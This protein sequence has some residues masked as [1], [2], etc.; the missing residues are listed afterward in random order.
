MLRYQQQF[1]FFDQANVGGALRFINLSE[2]VMNKD[3]GAILD[4]IVKEVEFSQAHMVNGGLVPRCGAQ[5]TKR[6]VRIGS[7]ILRPAIGI[8]LI[9]IKATNPILWFKQSAEWR[10]AKRQKTA[11]RF[12]GRHCAD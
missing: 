1:T 7:S 5:S 3:L 4:R 12:N 11:I 10:L 9:S 8:F 6:C 2:T